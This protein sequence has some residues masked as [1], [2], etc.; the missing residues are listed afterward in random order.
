[1]SAEENPEDYSTETYLLFVTGDYQGGLDSVFTPDVQEQRKVEEKDLTEEQRKELHAVK[2]EL[3]E[4]GNFEEEASDIFEVDIYTHSNNH[5][6]ISTGKASQIL[7]TKFYDHID[8]YVLDNP[9]D[10]ELD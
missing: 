4:L 10:F 7:G 1:M 8:V 5:F 3:K 6:W 9:D 2:E